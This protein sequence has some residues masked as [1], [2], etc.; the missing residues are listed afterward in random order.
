LFEHVL[1]LWRG[2]ALDGLSGAH[3]DDVSGQLAV[4]G[5]PPARAHGDPELAGDHL[6]GESA[7]HEA[8]HRAPLVAQLPLPARRPLLAELRRLPP[9]LLEQG[10]ER[11]HRP[12]AR[13]QQRSTEL[14]T[15]LGARS[16]FQLGAVAAQRGLLTV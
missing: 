12:R 8:E 2:P 1:G 15:K 9:H 4:G 13:Q 11:G 3:I 6:V 10:A 16:R 14:M 7:R 5:D